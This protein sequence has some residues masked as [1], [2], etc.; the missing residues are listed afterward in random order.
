MASASAQPYYPSLA[1][2]PS[3]PEHEDFEMVEHEAPAVKTETAKLE[4]LHIDDEPAEPAP[5]DPADPAPPANVATPQAKAAARYEPNSRGV[6]LR[7]SLGIV[8][9]PAPE[10]EASAT[11]VL[12]A[13]ALD[14][15]FSMT[16]NGG[17]QGCTRFLERFKEITQSIKSGPT[18]LANIYS[19]DTVARAY[20]VDGEPFT[21]FVPIDAVSESLMA[22]LRKSYKAQVAGSWTN[23]EDAI[24]H[25]RKVI[26]QKLEALKEIDPVAFGH[27]AG[28]VLLCTD[29]GTNMCNHEP[30][31]RDP[32]W[33][34]D[35]LASC[36][37]STLTI[38]TIAIGKGCKANH[39]KAMAGQHGCSE[40]C[41]QPV[42]VDD[43][44][45]N[46]FNQLGAVRGI[47]TIVVTIRRGDCTI[48]DQTFKRGFL[49]PNHHSELLDLDM[50]SLP[51]GG[52]LPGDVV[53]VSVPQSYDSASQKWN[54]GFYHIVSASKTNTDPQLFDAFAIDAEVD[55]MNDEFFEQSQASTPQEAVNLANGLVDQCRSL[56]AP[57]A[58]LKRL[59]TQAE[60]VYRSLSSK[61][62]VDATI[63]EEE[64]VRHFRSLGG[65]YSDGGDTSPSTEPPRV[66]RR[67]YGVN[68]LPAQHN[69]STSAP[70]SV[71]H[72]VMTA[73]S[74]ARFS[75]SG[76]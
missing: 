34:C 12:V 45:L 76:A 47:F 73:M 65:E 55:K 54:F 67:Y 5:A 26:G 42:N 25:G 48:F 53:K 15:S 17:T 35:E 27:T 30:Q 37:E 62:A 3:P 46:I 49:T 7:L 16:G 31:G 56:G 52:L 8:A 6:A 1:H 41:E 70:G 75:Q 2:L 50:T 28:V 36:S 68:G 59:A 74:R 33:L 63:S 40:L 32:T 60:E 58:T 39:L 19:F 57:P 61:C 11:N 43:A 38:S 51:E 10:S 21:Q 29:G 24:D 72:E 64:D 66:R 71:Q 20:D 9:E 69:R 23:H 22:S 4:K 14:S 44:I 13:V 18:M